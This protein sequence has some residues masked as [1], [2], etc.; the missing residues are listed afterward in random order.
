MNESP[1]VQRLKVEVEAYHRNEVDRL[2][3]EAMN[4]RLISSYGHDPSKGNKPCMI[5]QH[6]KD[7][8]FDCEDAISKLQDILST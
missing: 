7:E 6:G 5:N 3:K 1:E 2:G 8:Y 4:K